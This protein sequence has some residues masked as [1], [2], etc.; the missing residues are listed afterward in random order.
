MQ[1]MKK[2]CSTSSNS[3]SHVIPETF[4]ACHDQTSTAYHGFVSRRQEFALC[5]ASPAEVVSS[6]LLPPIC[7][8]PAQCSTHCGLRAAALFTGCQ[9]P[10]GWKFLS[11]K[12]S[13]YHALCSLVYS[14][15]SVLC[16]YLLNLRYLP[17]I[18]AITLCNLSMTF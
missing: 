8:S 3:S 1:K 2:L 5:H 16:C 4:T 10:Y 12:R 11:P 17:I 14:F 7:D 18:L 6:A 15:I 13:R 9:C